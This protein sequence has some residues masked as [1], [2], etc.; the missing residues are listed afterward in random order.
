LKCSNLPVVGSDV[1]VA[2]VELASVVA[3]VEVVGDAVL[4]DT[5]RVALNY[6]SELRRMKKHKKKRIHT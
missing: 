5:N 6:I 3:A 1:V 4:V 2:I